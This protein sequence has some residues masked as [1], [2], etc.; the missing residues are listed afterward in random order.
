[1]NDR[2]FIHGGKIVCILWSA[3]QVL[4]RGYRMGAE[5]LKGMKID[6][7]H[8]FQPFLPSDEEV[9]LTLC[10]CL[11]LLSK[12][13]HPQQITSRSVSRN[14]SLTVHPLHTGVITSWY[15]YGESFSYK[16]NKFLSVEFNGQR[17]NALTVALPATQWGRVVSFSFTLVHIFRELN[18]THKE[19]AFCA[20]SKS[21]TNC[22]ILC[23][24]D[25]YTSLSVS[26]TSKVDV[27]NLLTAYYPE[28]MV[29]IS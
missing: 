15:S 22:L 11:S 14:T 28:N 1:M 19:K 8:H 10:W 7:Y 6:C 5:G 9:I 24:R 13:T 16:T 27:T 23:I 3:F 2:C 25:I 29:Y 21:L 20:S 17:N 26:Y 18:T 4:W 12:Q